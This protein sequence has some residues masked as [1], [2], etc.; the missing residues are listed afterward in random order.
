MRIDVI[1][2][3]YPRKTKKTK[4]WKKIREFRAKCLP[5]AQAGDLCIPRSHVAVLEFVNGNVKLLYAADSRGD[6]LDLLNYAIK[7]TFHYLASGEV[8]S[9][10]FIDM[11]SPTSVLLPR[12]T[13]GLVIC[14]RRSRR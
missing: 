13:P 14:F 6:S 5:L 12:I 4:T 7:L 11:L 10:L 1:I 3:L 8:L 2:C 9:V